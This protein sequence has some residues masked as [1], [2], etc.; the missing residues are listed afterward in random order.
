MVAMWESLMVVQSVGNLARQKVGLMVGTL[1]VLWDLR[2]VDL[3]V[4][5]L[6]DS[7]AAMMV[8]LTV[9]D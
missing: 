3:L 1:A 9:V 2:L 8:D 6:V 5:L 4:E 7:L